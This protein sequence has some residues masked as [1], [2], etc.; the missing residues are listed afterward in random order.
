MDVR[1]R[2]SPGHFCC[3]QLLLNSGSDFLESSWLTANVDAGITA[4][5]LSMTNE[6]NAYCQQT[7]HSFFLFEKLYAT[8]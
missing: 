6:E 1:I 5:H 7:G 8:L 2:S 3:Q 4:I